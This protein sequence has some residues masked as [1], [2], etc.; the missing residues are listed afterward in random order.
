MRISNGVKAVSVILL[1]LLIDQIVKIQVKTTMTIG[2]S[3]TVSGNWFF[4]KFIENPGM[5]FGLDIPGKWGKPVLTVFRI[6]AVI[7]IGWY[8]RELVRKKVKTGLILCVALIFAGAMGNIIDSVFYGLIFNESTYFSIA[9]LLPKGGGYGSL[10]HGRVVDMLYFP[11]IKGTYPGWFPF[12]AGQDFIFFRPIFNI[13]D[14]SISVGIMT[15]LL[16]QKQFFSENR[17]IREERIGDEKI[18]TSS[19]PEA[20][21]GKGDG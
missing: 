8:L 12:N 7:A 16:F 14:S 13:A 6:I 4:I 18:I 20:V 1:I 15:I 5:A 17:P 11:I 21:N 2:E 3:I 10:L 19:S 9:Q